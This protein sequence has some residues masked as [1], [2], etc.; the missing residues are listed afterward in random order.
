MDFIV[1]LPPSNT[2][3]CICVIVDQF[4]KMVHFVPCK[5]TITGEDTAKLFIDNIYRYH[6]FLDDIVSDRR[7]QFVSKFWQSLF[8]ILQVEI[9]LSSAFHL[10]IDEQTEQVKQVLEQYLRCTINYQQDN[11]TSLLP[12]A[13]FVY[14]NSTYAS[15]Q[16]MLFYINYGHHPKIDILL[17]WRGESPVAK[18][19]AKQ[20]KE[21]Y[22]TMKMHL[23]QAQLCYKEIVDVRRKKHPSFQIGDKVWLLRCNIKT[24]RPYN[25]LDYWRIGPFRIEKQIN[26]VAYRLELPASM[27]IHCVFHVSLLKIYHESTISRRSQPTPPS[28]EIDGC[29]E[30]EVESILDSRIW[31]RK[32]EYFVHW[33]SY[34]ISKRTWEPTS[35][36]SNAPE[37]IR[38]FHHQHL[39]QPRTNHEFHT[40]KIKLLEG[41]QS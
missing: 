16:E 32:L 34:P 30:Y 12:L 10:Q 29:K 26:T 19:F 14:N 18:D 22:T 28:V 20:M 39:M 21:L 41:S 9:K 36:L 11:W 3:D 5:K 2:F 35:N 40:Q 31:L 33:Q 1:G 6:G 13:E 38:I 27:K 7:P 15:I 17:A 25:K 23:E 4:S 24:N 37:K 8:K